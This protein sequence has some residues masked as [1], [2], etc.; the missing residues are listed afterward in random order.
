MEKEIKKGNYHY[1]HHLQNK[2]YPFVYFTYV[3]A[4]FPEQE[5]V[6]AES[7]HN[8]W[9]GGV[10]RG[11]R[12]LV[13]FE[14]FTKNVENASISTTVPEAPPKPVDKSVEDA[15]ST[16]KQHGKF[17]KFLGIEYLK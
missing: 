11:A 16:L 8:S 12:A 2:E 13:T 15:I 17:K 10:C 4:I 14:E 7:G 6:L 5:L 9:H 1:V 3:V